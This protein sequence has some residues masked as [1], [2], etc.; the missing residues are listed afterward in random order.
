M[1][2]ARR[3]FGSWCEGH[4]DFVGLKRADPGPF[5]LALKPHS[6][7]VRSEALMLVDARFLLNALALAQG[8]VPARLA[9]TAG[10]RGGEGTSMYRLFACA[11]SCAAVSTRTSL[12]GPTLISRCRDRDRC[13]TLPSRASSPAFLRSTAAV[14]AGAAE[15]TPN[16][17]PNRPVMRPPKCST[18][19]HPP[20][21]E[22][23]LAN[24]EKVSRRWFW[25]SA[26]R[27][28]FA[29]RG[30]GSELA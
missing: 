17:A 25:L 11:R 27:T 2:D 28:R 7:D 13:L 26:V 9:G 8:G 4:R 20:A 18:T 16:T 10:R 12:G 24:W 19:E 14:W 3:R 1:I 30:S 5:A 21:A 29:G 6:I 23:L 22:N 15:P